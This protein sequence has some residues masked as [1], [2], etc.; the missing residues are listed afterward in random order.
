MFKTLI[1][2]FALMFSVAA[3]SNGSESSDG[4]TSSL[5]QEEVVASTIVE[6]VEETTLPPVEISEETGAWCLEMDG[7]ENVK[8]LLALVLVTPEEMNI[9]DDE[10]N[11]I[12]TA[13]IELSA[14]F[15]RYGDGVEV[16]DFENEPE[17]SVELEALT[18][19]Y[20]ESI[21][22]FEIEYQT[23]CASVLP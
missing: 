8:D 2:S 1:L 12:E 13:Y 4:T 21:D 5:P 6:T 23:M 18:A 14:L 17:A 15:D 9:T 7:S 20:G 11:D 19:E 16:P 22:R 10:R 3:C